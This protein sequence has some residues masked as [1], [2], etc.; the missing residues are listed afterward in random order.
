MCTKTRSH[1]MPLSMSTAP[2]S[3]KP[4]LAEIQ[5][6]AD[7]IPSPMATLASSPTALEGYRAVEAVWENG[8]FTTQER[9]IILFA[10][11]VENHCRFCTADHST[12]LKTALRT[13]AEIVFAIRHNI[14][15]PDAKFNAV[16]TLVKE[17]VR[18]RGH[19]QEETRTSSPLD[20]ERSRQWNCWSALR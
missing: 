18:G 17:L 8:S 11:S 5:K 9:Q 12:A 14:P 6:S 13:P 2:D 20:I 4:I 3:S 7:S 1:F 15:V 16:V 19:A 10:A